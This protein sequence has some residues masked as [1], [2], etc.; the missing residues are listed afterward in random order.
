MSTKL[1]PKAQSAHVFN[2]L[3]T[4]SLISIVKLFDDDCIAIFAKFDVKILKQNQVIITGLR[5]HTNGLCNIPLEPS[6][7][8]QQSLT[9]SHPRQANGILCYDTTKCQLAKHFHVVAFSPIKSNFITAINRFHFTSWLGLSASLISK[10]IPQSP[11]TVKGHLDQEQK[12]LGPLNFIKLSSTTSTPSKNSAPITFSLPSLTA[13]TLPP[14]HTPTKQD[15]SWF[16]LHAG[17][18]TFLSSITT[19][20]TPSTPTFSKQASPEYQYSL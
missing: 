6:S 11:F 18:N 2:N 13:T 17:N 3:T 15:D 1:S 9:R 7:P 4:G 16:S 19:T 14:N 20:T 12:N 8:A 5:D 10:Q